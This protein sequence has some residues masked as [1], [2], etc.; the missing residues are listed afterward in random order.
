[1]TYSVAFSGFRTRVSHVTQEVE[2]TFRN[3][4]RFTVSGLNGAPHLG[5]VDG[6]TAGGVNAQPHGVIAHFNDGEDDV[7]TN[8]DLFAYATAQHQHTGTLP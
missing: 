1:M 7:V 3:L 4:R 8:N 6:N 2:V 5:T